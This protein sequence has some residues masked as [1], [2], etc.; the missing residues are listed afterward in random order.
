MT[1]YLYN[2]YIQNFKRPPDPIINKYYEKLDNKIIENDL[3]IYLN[4]VKNGINYVSE[5]KLILAGLIRNNENNIPFLINFYDT[6][7]SYFKKTIFLIVENNSID[8]TREKLIQWNQKDE[9]VIILCDYDQDENIAECELNNFEKV[10]N[11]KIPFSERIK[12]LSYLRNVY[13]DY[14]RKDSILIHFDYLIVFDLDLFG[15]F[16]MDGILHSFYY[17]GINDTISAISCNGLVQKKNKEYEYYDSFAYIDLNESIEWD[18]S[19]D[20][21]SHDYD[22]LNYTTKK[23]MKNMKLDKVKSAFGGFCIYNLKKII[24]TKAKYSYSKN[25]KLSCEHSHF[26]SFFD[27]VYVNPKMIFLIHSV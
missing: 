27:G 6:L 24:D 20:K 17:L 8:K 21:S 12:K 25:N 9:S 16:F 18:T 14:I 3:K 22:V 23:Y 10:Y 15:K 19:F 11:D 13:I 5:K 2:F 4:Q 26:H 7:K 1:N